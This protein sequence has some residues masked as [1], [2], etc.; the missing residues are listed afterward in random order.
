MKSCSNYCSVSLLLSNSN[1]DNSHC[2]PSNYFSRNYYFLLHERSTNYCLAHLHLLFCCNLICN[3]RVCLHYSF[4]ILSIMLCSLLVSVS[5]FLPHELMFFF[6]LVVVRTTIISLVYWRDGRTSLTTINCV[7]GDR[8]TTQPHHAA[9]RTIPH[10]L[11]YYYDDTNGIDCCFLGWCWFVGKQFHVRIF[12]R[13]LSVL[14]QKSMKNW[15]QK[16]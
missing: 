13:N 11:D 5:L 10:L 15:T 4:F 16:D 9:I 12:A 8:P 7:D 2:F 14:L 3:C 6:C 1:A